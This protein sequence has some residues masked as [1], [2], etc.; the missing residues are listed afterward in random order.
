[1]ES[2]VLKQSLY[3]D[4]VGEGRM[5]NGR[6]NEKRKIEKGHDRQIKESVL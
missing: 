6:G 5:S 2:K 1:M 4:D 3:L